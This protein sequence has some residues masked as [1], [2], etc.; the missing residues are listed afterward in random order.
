MN[1]RPRPASCSRF[2]WRRSSPSPRPR[3][4]GRGTS[5]PGR[6][7]SRSSSSPSPPGSPSSRVRRSHPGCPRAL[8]VTL[9]VLGSLFAAIG[10]WQAQTR[11]LFFA[12]DV[13]VANAYTTFFRVTSLFKDPS[14]YGRY[15]IVPIVVLLVVVLSASWPG[16][17]LGCGDDRRRVPLLGPLLLVL[18]VELRR[19]LR[20]HV[21]RRARGIGSTAPNPPGRL[22]ARRHPG[23]SRGR[24]GCRERTLRERRD[25]RPLATRERDPRRV[26]GPSGRR[27]RDRWPA[28]RERGGIGQG[29]TEPECLAHDAAH[30]ARGAR[31]FSASRSMLWVLAA[32]AWALWLLTRTRSDLRHGAGCGAPR[33]RRPFVAVR[34]ILRGSADVGS[35]RPGAGGYRDTSG[36]ASAAGTLTCGRDRAASRMPRALKWILLVLSVL[37][38]ALGGLLLAIGLTND[39]PQGALDTELDDVTVSVPTLPSGAEASS[40]AAGAGRRRALLA[41]VRCRSAALA[42]AARRSARSSGAEAA[43]V[44]RVAE[45]HRVPAHVLRG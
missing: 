27:R 1:G 8:V 29:L 12:R 31:A 28:A 43:L 36:R 20:R 15:L 23:R 37:V 4:C 35:F 40:E 9:V 39:P 13:E 45:L 7:A 30:G 32:A 16:D 38:M 3:T 42:R 44:A 11:T 10:I 24:S 2:R 26:S 21:R 33:P 22:C 41:H 18:A 14:L 6:S 5:A 17:R 34:G 25:E 19:A